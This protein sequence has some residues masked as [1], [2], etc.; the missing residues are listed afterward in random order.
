MH[1]F[2]LVKMSFQSDVY[3]KF[4]KQ[5][6]YNFVIL[7]SIFLFYIKET[8]QVAMN[9]YLILIVQ[10]TN[11]QHQLPQRVRLNPSAAA[12]QETKTSPKKRENIEE[13]K[14]KNASTV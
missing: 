8:I 2:C 14:M 10:Y 13:L 6:P 4:T 11:H 12:D 1:G 5:K 9:I 7:T 3:S